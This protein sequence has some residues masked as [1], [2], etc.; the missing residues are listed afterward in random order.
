V[1]A[2]RMPRMMITA[3][4]SI[5]VK[6]RDLSDIRFFKHR[7]RPRAALRLVSRD[8]ALVVPAMEELASELGD[9]Q[10][11]TL[12][13][14]IDICLVIVVQHRQ[15]DRYRGRK[16]LPSRRLSISRSSE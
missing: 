5:K 3:T 13:L 11:H 7:I 9:R 15:F 16:S 10:P 6:P 12:A 4:S 2:D 14:G 1:I 8:R